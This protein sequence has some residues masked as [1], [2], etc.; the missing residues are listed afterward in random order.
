MC[1]AVFI[2]SVFCKIHAFSQVPVIGRS[3]GSEKTPDHPD[4]STSSVQDSHELPLSPISEASSGYFSTSVSTATLS[5]V[6]AAS[7]DL[8]PSPNTY[9]TSRRG[10]DECEHGP[11]SPAETGLQHDEAPQQN[12]NPKDLQPA[13]RNGVPGSH[14]ETKLV[15]VPPLVPKAATDY[16][17]SLQK[18]RPSNL[19]SFSPILPENEKEKREG[20]RTE[21]SSDET[22]RDAELPHWLRLGESVAVANSKCGTVRYVGHADFSEGIWVG[23]ELDTPTGQ[24]KTRTA[25]SSSSSGI[26]TKYI[27]MHRLRANKTSMWHLNNNSLMILECL[28]KYFYFIISQFKNL[29]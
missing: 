8:T 1:G 14:T 26:L 11:V 9:D 24:S 10:A 3:L 17:F 21:G 16:A 20:G 2:Y 7:G 22:I 18:V 23:V 19:K 27:T 29:K 4:A 25:A 28:Q 5:D 15:T 13:S 6:S 12:P